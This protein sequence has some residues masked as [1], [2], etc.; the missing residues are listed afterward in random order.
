MSPLSNEGTE[1]WRNQDSR[2]LHK[3]LR[4]A[5]KE[6]RE[7]GDKINSR[8]MGQ[9]LGISNQ[10][11]EIIEFSNAVGMATSIERALRQVEQEMKMSVAVTMQQCYHDLKV[12][13]TE[14]IDWIKK[15]PT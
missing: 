8:D 1:I 4:V 6:R 2:L 15:W 10:D 7:S 13:K 3:G 9:I 11:G 5:M 14:F 12:E